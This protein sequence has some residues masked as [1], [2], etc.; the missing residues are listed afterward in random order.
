ML[1]SPEGRAAI[2]RGAAEAKLRGGTLLLARHVTATH[3][4]AVT[5]AGRHALDQLVARYAGEGIDLRVLEPHSSRSPAETI[6]HA[7]AAEN[8]DLIVIGVRRRSRVGKLVLGSNAADI[9]LG[10]EAPVLAV[11]PK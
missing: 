2:E 6:L 11:K 4:E 8:V 1:E 10:A 7:A 5:A 9:L 3:D